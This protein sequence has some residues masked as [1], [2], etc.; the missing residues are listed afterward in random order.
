MGNPLF[1]CVCAGLPYFIRQ[2]EQ[3]NVTRNSPFN[4]TCQA[5]GPPE[6]VEIYWFQN[7]IKLN[8]KPHISPSVLTVPGELGA[9]LP[10]SVLA[11]GTAGNS[12][13]GN[14]PCAI[15][16]LVPARRGC[17][18]AMHSP[19]A[20]LGQEA[21][22]DSLWLLP[23][24]PSLEEAGYSTNSFLSQQQIFPPA[25]GCANRNLAALL[26]C[27]NVGAHLVSVEEFGIPSVLCVHGGTQGEKSLVS[28]KPYSDFAAEAKDG[29]FLAL[30]LRRRRPVVSEELGYDCPVLASS[31]RR[32]SKGSESRKK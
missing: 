4:L 19:G 1:P 8:Q 29:V 20:P 5:V 25:S 6:P 2:P 30:L 10:W 23:E 18:C 31:S 11:M 3:L 32:P 21:P 14:V 27:W 12:T 9:S 17:S 28:H 26:G 15:P 24:I 16:E 7:N 13:A 22:F